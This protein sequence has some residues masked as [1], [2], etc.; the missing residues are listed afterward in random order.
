MRGKEGRDE[1]ARKAGRSGSTNSQGRMVAGSA[2]DNDKSTTSSYDTN[3]I[4]QPTQHHYTTNH[5]SLSPSLSQTQRLTFA[6]V[7]ADPSSHS[8]DHTLWLFKYLLLH[9]AVKAPYK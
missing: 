2:G 7:K 6:L 8:I 5:K 4:D 9:E 3:Q 1:R